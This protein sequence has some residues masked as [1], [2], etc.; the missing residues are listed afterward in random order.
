[1]PCEAQMR[2]PPPESRPNTYPGAGVHG[3]PAATLRATFGTQSTESQAADASPA[4]EVLRRFVAE[5]S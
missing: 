2:V 1:M 5:F 3:A 4:H